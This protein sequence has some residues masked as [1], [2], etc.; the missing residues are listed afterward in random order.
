MKKVLI[1][2]E[3]MEKLGINCTFSAN[4]PWVYLDTVN[5]KQ[6][7]ERHFSKYKF[8]IAFLPVRNDQQEE[9]TD[10]KEIFKIIRKY[11]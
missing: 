8:T 9:F 7:T 1:F 3:R 6:V 11:K 2:K 5:G 10:I 4:Y